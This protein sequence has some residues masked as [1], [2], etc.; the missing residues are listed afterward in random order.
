MDEDQIGLQI[1]GAERELALANA[2]ALSAW[3]RLMASIGGLS[4]QS[5]QQLQLEALSD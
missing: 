2:R 3:A 4:A 1:I 5:M